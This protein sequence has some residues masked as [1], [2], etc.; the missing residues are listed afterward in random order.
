MGQLD[1]RCTETNGLGDVLTFRTQAVLGLVTQRVALN[2]HEH[3]FTSD[4]DWGEN[5]IVH[6]MDA[7]DWVLDDIQNRASDLAVLA[8]AYLRRKHG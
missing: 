8:I 3:Y 7:V 1:L 2:E 6:W 5:L 4:Q